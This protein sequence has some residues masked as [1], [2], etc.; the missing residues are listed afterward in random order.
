[1]SL[2][3]PSVII[4]AVQSEM[5]GRITPGAT[6]SIRMGWPL[7]SVLPLPGRQA[8][9]FLHGLPLRRGPHLRFGV[10]LVTLTIVSRKIIDDDEVVLV[11]GTQAEDA[12]EQDVLL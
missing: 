3:K 7:T 11:L 12:A 2:A 1:M 10:V 8:V 5:L 4:T 6:P 9:A